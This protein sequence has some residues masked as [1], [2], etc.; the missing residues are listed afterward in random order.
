MFE[1]TS[2]PTLPPEQP[3]DL[4][5]LF[6]ADE[7][8]INDDGFTKRVME[9]AHAGIGWRQ[10]IIYGAGMAGF[11]AAV[12]GITKMAPY[13]PKMP[14]WWGGVSTQLQNAPSID[15]TNPAVMI[16]AAVV[17]GVSFLALAVAMQE[18]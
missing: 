8:A 5:R 4:E 3:D 11:G 14:D 9:Q 18:R 15:P 10:T 6:S 1:G 12:A 2:M 13:L 17:A 16:S 7:A